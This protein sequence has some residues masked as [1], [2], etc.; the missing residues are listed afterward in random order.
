MKPAT[1]RKTIFSVLVIKIP[2]L[3]IYGTLDFNILDINY[4]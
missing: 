4:L 2:I 3:I 1:Y